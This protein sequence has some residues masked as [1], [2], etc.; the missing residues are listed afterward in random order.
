MEHGRMQ[1]RKRDKLARDSLSLPESRL[2]APSIAWLNSIE[3]GASLMRR[4]KHTAKPAAGSGLLSRGWRYCD[5]RRERSRLRVRRADELPM[6]LAI[7]VTAHGFWTLTLKS[8]W[9]RRT[10]A[11][12]ERL[13]KNCR[14]SPN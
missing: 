1:W 2:E 4:R 13:R 10:S 12:P 14:N 11:Q 7:L 6:R 5:W 8:C 3:C 9:R